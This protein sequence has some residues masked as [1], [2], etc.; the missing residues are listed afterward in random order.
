LIE[1]VNAVNL[2]SLVPDGY[3]LKGKTNPYVK[4]TGS[5]LAR[6]S[7]IS[8]NNVNPEWKESFHFLI[9][10]TD[11]NLT[12]CIEVYHHADQSDEFIGS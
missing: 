2:P 9:D 3:I 7:N 5:G 4:I 10:E 12:L 6:V 8:E 1:V 11:H